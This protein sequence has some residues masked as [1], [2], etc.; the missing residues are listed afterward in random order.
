MHASRDIVRAY[1]GKRLLI[2]LFNTITGLAGFKCEQPNIRKA[3]FA[4]AFSLQLIQWRGIR[5]TFHR[6]DDQA[7][8]CLP[9]DQ[10]DKH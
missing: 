2:I 5:F 8:D 1:S 9:L 10:V 6:C 4:A 7:D 3:L